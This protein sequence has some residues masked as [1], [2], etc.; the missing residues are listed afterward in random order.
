MCS[1]VILLLHNHILHKAYFPIEEKNCVSPHTHHPVPILTQPH[2]L[3]AVILVSNSNTVIL[4]VQQ[5]SNMPRTTATA[6]L[7][8]SNHIHSN[9]IHSNSIAGPR[10]QQQLH[11]LTA[12]PS[13]ATAAETVAAITF[14]LNYS[15][16]YKSI[17][18]VCF[19]LTPAAALTAIALTAA[20]FF[21][22][23]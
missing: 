8:D 21:L 4:V 12:T 3:D 19:L 9:C 7:L 20:I 6:S 17:L 18:L 5:Q 16:Y 13:T 10:Q 15:L 1:A 14:I 22:S 2:Y 23:K 11:G